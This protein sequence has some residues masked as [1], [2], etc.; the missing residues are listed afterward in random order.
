MRKSYFAVLVLIG[1]LS[2]C[3]AR[4]NEDAAL[5]PTGYSSREVQRIIVY[6]NGMRYWYTEKG[7]DQPLEEGFE[8][9]GEV[10]RV[11]NQEYPEEEF[12]GTWLDTGQEIYASQADASKIYVKYDSGYA[13]FERQDAATE[14]PVKLQAADYKLHGIEASAWTMDE[15]Y[16]RILSSGDTHYWINQEGQLWVRGL[17]DYGQLGIGTVIDHY[18]IR[19][20]ETSQKVFDHV[21]HISFSG[22][23]FAAFITEDNRLYGMGANLDGVMGLPVGE[24]D[25]DNPW[26]TVS[27]SPT[28]LMENVA[29]ALCGSRT[30]LALKEDGSVWMLGS[31]EGGPTPVQVMEHVRFIVGSG[32]SW[33]AITEEGE[34]F[35]WGENG[36]GQCG[37]A[38]T[39][40]VETPQ[41]AAEQVS[42]CWIP[43]WKNQTVIKKT[44]GSLQV[45][46][47]GVGRDIRT[48]EDLDDPSEVKEI[49]YSAE[50]LPAELVMPE[51]EEADVRFDGYPEADDYASILPEAVI[52]EQDGTFG[53][54]SVRW[55][56]AD[57]GDF[58]HFYYQ[59]TKP[60]G[61]MDESEEREHIGFAITGEDIRLACGIHTGMPA[62]DAVDIVPGLYH[63]RWDRPEWAN[64]LVWSESGFP[65]GWCRQFPE[66]LIA[67][68]ENGE[69]MPLYVGF[70]LDENEIIRAISFCCPT[71]G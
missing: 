3:G 38:G 47:Y 31:R 51:V 53:G 69:E 52:M 44:D 46:G 29:Y 70:L 54:S 33:G 64:A 56:I 71:A 12:G 43:K 37:V 60:D 10:G 2:A 57:A 27:S 63:F 28:L 23:Y 40:Y 65:K 17:N 26:M 20:E 58:V 22:E 67:E 24:M 48:A 16:Q 19:Y 45:C 49:V 61:S 42:M 62:E 32:D 59:F 1:L 6:Y 55:Y 15:L 18:D 39:D 14:D 11:D 35:L 7:F 36:Y 4:E 5:T 66:I 34:L 21:K 68:V 8:K 41:K 9:V 30:I 25:K 13:V 50:F